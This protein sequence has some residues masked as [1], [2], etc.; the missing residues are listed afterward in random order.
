MKKSS[1]DP[2][3]KIVEKI[4]T[5]TKYFVIFVLIGAVMFGFVLQKCNRDSNESELQLQSLQRI[6]QYQKESSVIDKG[7]D[8][9]NR[10]RPFITFSDK[11]KLEIGNNFLKKVEVG[12]SISKKKN[13]TTFYIYR[14]NQTFEYDSFEDSQGKYND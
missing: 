2:D 4:L 6:L 8:A 1:F 3:N 13:T 7:I 10:N 9:Q 11:G 12:D 14:L 5:D